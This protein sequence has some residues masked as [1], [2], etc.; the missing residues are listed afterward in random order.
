MSTH[1]EGSNVPKTKPHCCFF[2][3]PE[4]AEFDIQ[5]ND[6]T[7]EQDTQ[8]CE[9]HVGQLLTDAKAHTVTRIGE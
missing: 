6:E 5:P 8:A 1:V 4:N 9:K 2:G 3:C 7:R